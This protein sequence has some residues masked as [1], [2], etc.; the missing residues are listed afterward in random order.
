[1]GGLTADNLKYE[2][3]NPQRIYN[4]D[5]TFA[6]PVGSS[7]GAVLDSRC[8]STE[9]PARGFDSIKINY[10]GTPGFK[11]PGKR[12]TPQ[13]WSCTFIE[14][15][16]KKVF[17]AIHGWQQAIAHDRLGIG[18]PDTL[19]KAD[20]YLKLHDAAGATTLK[21]K[22]RGC[23]PQDRPPVALPYA[24]NALVYYTVTFSYDDWEEVTTGLG[25]AISAVVGGISGTVGSI[26]NTLGF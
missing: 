15:T 24:E 1:M 8:Q 18:M 13:T 21:I 5:C 25:G 3:S 12:T 22:I 23:Y 4:W 7:N 2:L 20:L 6:N 10:K 9:I 26:R 16:D 14:S 11:V 17:D 19:I